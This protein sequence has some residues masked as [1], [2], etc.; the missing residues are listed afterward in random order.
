MSKSK[1][2]DYTKIMKCARCG[3][4]RRVTRPEKVLCVDCRYVLSENEREL[5]EPKMSVAA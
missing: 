3:C 4:L 1:S 5:W 2:K